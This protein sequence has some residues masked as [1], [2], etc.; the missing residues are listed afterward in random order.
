MSKS[1]VTM[2]QRLCSCCGKEYETNSILL[3]TKMRERFDM[4]TTTGYGQC[5]KCKK[6]GYVTM[7]ECDP[8]KSKRTGST[9]HSS[10]AFRTGK[11]VHIRK[12]VFQQIF[13]VKLPKDDLCFIEPEVVESLSKMDKKG[14]K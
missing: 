6:E 4:L 8:E 11:V 1:Y 13:N 3:D 12:K 9:L 7:V 5:N 14:G 2:E 10:N